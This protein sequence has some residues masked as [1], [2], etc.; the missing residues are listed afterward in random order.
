MNTG[1]RRGINTVTLLAAT[2][3][4]S[5]AVFM[6]SCQSP[7]MPAGKAE[8]SADAKPFLYKLRAM[9]DAKFGVW[10]QNKKDYTMNL[11]K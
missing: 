2:G 9:D 6:T 4:L 7:D 10:H 11:R 1:R 3:L 8:A 5:A